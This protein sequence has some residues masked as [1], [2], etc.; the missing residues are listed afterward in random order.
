GVSGALLLY[1]LT[2]PAT[3]E[4]TNEWVELVRMHNTSLPVILVGIKC[5]LVKP[6]DIND[7]E[8]NQA[9]SNFDLIANVKTSSKTG[10]NV[11]DVFSILIKK[12]KKKTTLVS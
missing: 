10:K 6:E 4:N 3:I 9:L 12:K 8:S 5:D 1:D 7:D 2:N 11:E